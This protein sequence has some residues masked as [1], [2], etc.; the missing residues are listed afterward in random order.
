M[1]KDEAI[2]QLTPLLQE[3]FL[4]EGVEAVN[5]KVD[6]KP[7][8][9][10]TIGPAHVAYASDH[11]YGRLGEDVCE[12]VPCAA[13]FKDTPKCGRPYSSHSHDTVLFL[14]LKG[15][16]KQEKVKEVLAGA[17]VVN[18]MAQAKID[19]FVFV[20]TVDKYRIS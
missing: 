13:K 14:K 2:K 4:V 5:Y 20:E 15:H 1:D 7:G 6:G 3:M 11:C 18:V 16:L 12:K 9:P 10:F 17:P 8:H 19:G